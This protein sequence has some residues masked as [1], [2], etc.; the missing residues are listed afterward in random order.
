MEYQAKRKVWRADRGFD[1]DSLGSNLTFCG[2]G[3]SGGAAA[4]QE[5]P[6]RRISKICR[7]EMCMFT[8]VISSNQGNQ[9]QGCRFVLNFISLA[10]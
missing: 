3:G 4:E 7:C 1:F 6:S 5:R 2:C 10:T 8:R 9:G